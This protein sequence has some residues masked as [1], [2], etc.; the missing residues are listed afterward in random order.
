M[1]HI[2]I[3]GVTFMMGL[4]LL[5]GLAG[6]S[7]EAQ[8]PQVPMGSPPL[9]APSKAAC[10]KNPSITFT[11]E[12]TRELGNLQRAFM[13]E[14]KPLSSELRD[15]RLELRF[16]VSD[17][18][19]QSQVLFDKQRKMSAIQAKFENLRFSYLV[20][21]RSILTKDQL[22]RFPPDCP[23]KMETGYGAGRG[24]GKGLQ[25]GIR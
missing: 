17:P 11:E 21:A 5:K 3:I 1:R 8:Q 19:I 22:G 13:E 7:S 14:A 24:H 18:Q 16:A 23:L 10:W 15:L 25:K 2:K 12:Q 6:Q 20:K 4:I 9:Q